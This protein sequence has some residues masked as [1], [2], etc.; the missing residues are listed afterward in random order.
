VIAA[1]GKIGPAAVRSLSPALVRSMPYK[2]NE[3]RRYKIPKARYRVTN[4]AG[5][6]AQHHQDAER[7]P[8]RG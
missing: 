7:R 6:I 2:F 5:A 3:H 4:E 8:E 1:D